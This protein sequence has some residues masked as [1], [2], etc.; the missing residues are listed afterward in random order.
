M[1]GS[2]DVLVGIKGREYLGVLALLQG[3][4]LEAG[5]QFR[6]AIDLV[7]A[8]GDV[9]NLSGLYAHLAYV[10][11]RTGE[12]EEALRACDKAVEYGGQ[13]MDAFNAIKLALHLKGLG[14]LAMGYSDA[15]LET[16]VYRWP[17]PGKITARPAGM[18]T[19]VRRKRPPE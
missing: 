12:Y 9:A 5:S 3:R 2:R 16:A 10:A 1:V 15:A 14:Q 13:S 8:A 18:A 11:I 4:F 19:A 17:L 7:E 6:Q